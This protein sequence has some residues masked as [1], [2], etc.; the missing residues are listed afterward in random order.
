MHVFHD[1]LNL[2][3]YS[4]IPIP[5]DDLFFLTIGTFQ[6]HNVYDKFGNHAS[7]VLMSELG[8]SVVKVRIG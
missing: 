7:P 4:S 6:P 8:Y 3:G 1:S 2:L 5:S